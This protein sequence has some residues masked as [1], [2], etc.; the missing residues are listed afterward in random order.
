MAQIGRDDDCMNMTVEVDRLKL[1]KTSS[2]DADEIQDRS[3]GVSQSEVH[4][5][6]VVK[7]VGGARRSVRDV[8]EVDIVTGLMMSFVGFTLSL[9]TSDS[10]TKTLTTLA[11]R[12]A[13]MRFQF[14][15]NAI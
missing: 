11:L 12:S 2:N 13:E 14:L 4:Q 7:T 5:G 15:E 8:C 10:R 1:C 6:M 9:S 3:L